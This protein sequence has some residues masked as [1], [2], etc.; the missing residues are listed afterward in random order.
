MKLQHLIPDEYILGSPKEIIHLLNKFLSLI[1][2]SIDKNKEQLS[3][4]SKEI[5][6]TYVQNI[7]KFIEIS[8][9]DN[10]KMLYE[11]HEKL[12]TI[13]EEELKIIYNFNL[14]IF[15]LEMQNIVNS[16]INKLPKIYWKHDSSLYEKIFDF[17][18]NNAREKIHKHS[19]FKNSILIDLQQDK[20]HPIIHYS[21]G[22]CYGLA[23]LLCFEIISN[24]SNEKSRD[25]GVFETIE[26]LKKSE[27]M[28][29]F[30]QCQESQHFCLEEKISKENTVIRYYAV[31]CLDDIVF[32]NDL[33]DNSKKILA[34]T[35][36][37]LPYTKTT[38]STA[39]QAADTIGNI[40]QEK[41]SILAP[42][43]QCALNLSLRGNYL[44]TW[45]HFLGILVIKNNYYFIDA[46]LGVFKFDKLDDL[47]KFVKW[48]L[49]EMKYCHMFNQFSITN[50]RQLEQIIPTPEK[51]KIKELDTD[52]PIPEKGFPS[53]FSKGWVPFFRDLF[54][55]AYTAQAVL[56]DVVK[57]KTFNKYQHRV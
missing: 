47:I 50:F 29:Y 38:L 39:F 28:M 27:N 18:N 17:S 3:E 32:K 8:S 44:N 48:E 7:E 41:L 34:D 49:N 12:K 22:Y 55:K 36:I 2:T 43:D 35:H 19:E 53:K 25:R 46:N 40:L 26:Q 10:A 14:A 5:I 24:E 21:G 16:F 42:Q 51:L 1:T 9:A 37:I 54:N 4:Q 52:E 33:C 13:P 11:Y 20:I 45:G 56:Q 30:E 31:G 15:T 23:L 57:A 6:N